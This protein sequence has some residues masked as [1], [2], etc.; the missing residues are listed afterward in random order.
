MIKSSFSQ[1]STNK[2]GLFGEVY[3]NVALSPASSPMNYGWQGLSYDGAIGKWNNLARTY[4]QNTGAFSSQD[5]I[6]IMGGINVYGSRGNNPLIYDDPDGLFLNFVAGGIY[7]GIAGGVGAYITSGGDARSVAIG[8]FVGFAIG[9]LNPL[10]A[11]KLGAAGA[12]ALS[13]AASSAAGQVAGN[14]SKGNTAFNNFS[15][16]AVA[17]SAAAGL[18][19]GGALSGAGFV[20]VGV[21]GQLTTS[22]AEGIIGAGGEVAGYGIGNLLT[23]HQKVSC[24]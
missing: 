10:I 23:N 24:P 3:A 18:T 13:G 4:D 17:G 15:Y 12:S 16:G 8:A 1:T 14:L 6:G 20:P 2:V 19:V 5:P 11:V 7:G 9:T 21:T 22:V